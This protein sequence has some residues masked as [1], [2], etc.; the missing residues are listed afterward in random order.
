MSIKESE[1]VHHPKLML[2]SVRCVRQ[3]PSAHTLQFVPISVD[4]KEFKYS[5]RKMKNIA[6][7]DDKIFY[8]IFKDTNLFG[9]LY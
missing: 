1:I 2:K 7:L 8:R 3:R 5:R 6:S 4:G 9:K